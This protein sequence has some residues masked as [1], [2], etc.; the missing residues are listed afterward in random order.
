MN[1]M[2]RVALLL[3]LGALAQ[4]AEV[5]PELSLGHAGH[6]FDHLGN[7]GEQA[8]STLVGMPSS[9]ARWEV[10]AVSFRNPS[11]QAGS[12]RPGL[13]WETVIESGVVGFDVIS[14]DDAGV[15]TRLNRHL[16]PARNSPA[17]GRYVW[18]SSES[19]DPAPERLD[20]SR[21]HLRVWG[22]DGRPVHWPLRLAEVV[23]GAE[24]SK[25]VAGALGESESKTE[26]ASSAWI[27]APPVSPNPGIGPSQV[28]ASL[29]T[30][31]VRPTRPAPLAGGPGLAGFDA[32]TGVS[33][34]YRATAAELAS[35]LNQPLADI[36]ARLLDHSLGLASLGRPLRW[37]LAS[38]KDACL[39]FLP[40][41]RSVYLRG[42]VFQSTSVPSPEPTRRDA[43]AASVGAAAVGYVEQ[44][45]ENDVFA[46]TTLPGSLEEDF[47]VWD[48]YL[49]AHPVLG[50]RT[51]SV[52]VPDVAADAGALQLT[53]DLASTSETTHAFEAT[54]NGRSLGF[55]NWAGRTLQS[56]K[57]PLGPKDLKSGTN[58]L[59]LSSQGDRTSLCY[60]DRF[61]FRYARPLVVAEGSLLFEVDH[62]GSRVVRAADG[63]PVD[64]W[65]ISDP[66][67]PVILE[68]TA[69]TSVLGGGTVETRIF[70]AE[71]GH[72]YVA[73]RPDAP[74]NVL[75]WRT[76]GETPLRTDALKVDYLVISPESLIEPAQR[77]AAWRDSQG[78]ASRVVTLT[79]MQ[80][81]FS[82]GAP[83]P[84][85]LREL[86]AHARQHWQSAPRYVVLLGDGTYDYRA[87]L[88]GADNLL[89]PPLILTSFGRA[90]ADPQMLDSPTARTSV[91]RLSVKTSADLHRLIN[92]MQIYENS[93]PPRP[94]V[95]LLH[96][97]LP[98]AGG[99]FIQDSDQ[100]GA[101][102]DGALAVKKA[103]NTGV[104]SAVV[105][106]QVRDELGRGVTWWNYVGHGGRDRMGVEYVTIADVPGLSFGSV[107]PLVTGMTCAM[108]QFALP[109][110]DCLAEALLLKDGVGPLAVWSP[111]GFSINYQA[112][113]LNRIFAEELTYARS[114]DRVGDVLRRSRNRFL[115]SGNDAIT[116]E[117]YNLLGDP[118]L[119]LPFAAPAIPPRLTVRPGTS[120]APPWELV[121]AG[122]AGSV[123]QIEATDSLSPSRSDWTPVE[124]VRF[125]DSLMI[126]AT[127]FLD[128]RSTH[129][130]YRARRE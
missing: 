41:Q 47:W 92:R 116:P 118:A 48:N 56:W 43:R 25:P 119:R 57:L 34:V 27:A 46:V 29:A 121:L 50:T 80:H 67:T 98:D 33:G 4:A 115:E 16:I 85:A 3:F 44:N 100:L 51:Y 128:P 49:G 74:R 14:V 12:V 122:E 35:A 112:S 84:T 82:F 97:D 8:D 15:E 107:S 31:G 5:P 11:S 94:S 125:P 19:L 96:A 123:Y 13:A 78:L 86:L 117:F 59:V 99:E 83:R 63:G 111:S 72:H 76:V 102:V 1:W 69:E 127:N 75:R 23:G 130:F 103:Y 62:A 38:G 101:L 6:A 54:L 36:R 126:G 2:L 55:L 90:A 9:G 124:W 87:V 39:F 104:G 109:G 7:I 26:G 18:D 64:V 79:Q 68:M 113:Q 32:F 81:E 17:G 66:A 52:N 40:E 20:A 108:G 95:A 73:F 45:I 60:L 53:I 88:G 93:Q 70:E 105:R 110:L 120:P 22:E 10:G 61:R 114:E 91:G 37:T 77:L 24:S 71:I 28:E 129:R 89:P 42:N 58:S 30:A 65:D 21:I 106:S